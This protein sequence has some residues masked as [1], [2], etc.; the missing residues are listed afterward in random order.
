MADDKVYRGQ[1]NYTQFVKVRDTAAGNAGSGMNRS[2][3]GGGRG[4]GRHITAWTM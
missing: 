2:V 3:G 4:G 1:N